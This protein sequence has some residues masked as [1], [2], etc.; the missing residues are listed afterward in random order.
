MS[1]IVWIHVFAFWVMP[2]GLDL[3]PP[4]T[5]SCIR[6]RAMHSLSAG[7]FKNKGSCILIVLSS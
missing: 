5:T 6:N 3:G 2:G 1:I 4:D 7:H